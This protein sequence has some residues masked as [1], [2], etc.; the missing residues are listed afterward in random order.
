[1][2]QD[3]ATS[4]VLK[5][6]RK[7]KIKSHKI[8]FVAW[9]FLLIAGAYAVATYIHLIAV[10]VWLLAYVYLIYSW[11]Y[12]RQSDLIKDQLEA[13]LKFCKRECGE[14]NKELKQ[15]QQQSE[16]ILEKISKEHDIDIET[17]RL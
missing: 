3:S 5:E 6:R 13:D 1:M 4:N 8:Q 11:D 2:A 16:A 17:Y 14:I 9:I 10:L 12:Y 15:H 7:R